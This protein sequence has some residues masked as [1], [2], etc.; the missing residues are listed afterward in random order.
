MQKRVSDIFIKIKIIIDSYSSSQT[1]SIY[2]IPESIS[3]IFNEKLDAEISLILQKRANTILFLLQ[4]RVCFTN[5]NLI[6]LPI[7]QAVLQY[8]IHSLCVHWL[9]IIRC[10]LFGWVLKLK[11]VREL[12]YAHMLRY[13]KS[14][15][16]WY[17]Y[18]CF[19]VWYPLISKY[20]W[21]YTFENY[22]PFDVT[23]LYCCFYQAKSLE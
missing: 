13:G 11:I 20:F 22:I 14:Y 18:L 19:S 17:Q 6:H 2:P 1:T 5:N 9:V 16:D 23:L 8:L 15:L 21:F 3:L 12:L 4:K 7:V 10:K